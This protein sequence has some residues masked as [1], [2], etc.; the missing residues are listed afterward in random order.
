MATGMP[1]VTKSPAFFIH[2]KAHP[3]EREPRDHWYGTLT[4][5]H[6][7]Q[8]V[9]TFLPHARGS[10]GYFP[11]GVVFPLGFE[12]REIGL[13]VLSPMQTRIGLGE[14]VLSQGLESELT[15][16][17]VQARRISGL[18]SSEVY[19]GQ[20]PQAVRVAFTRM[21]FEVM[22]ANPNTL[23]NRLSQVLPRVG[24]DPLDVEAVQ[25]ELLATL[26]GR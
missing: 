1:R 9:T 3:I 5:F 2:W 19:I 21:I 18:R 4:L 22:V 15:G 16:R 23:V 13:K 26:R 10:K 7:S 14:Q 6:V 20:Q 11:Q 24:V 25:R 8:G 17:R 12:G